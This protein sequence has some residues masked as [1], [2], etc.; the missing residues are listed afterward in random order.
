MKRLLLACAFLLPIGAVATHAALAAG[1]SAQVA[2]VSAGTPIAGQAVVVV[3]SEGK[4][5]G[6]TDQN[7]LFSV[8]ISGKYYRLKVNNKPVTGIFQVSQGTVQVDINNL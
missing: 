2:V 8:P 3:A 5:E 7:G 1:G 4:Y 6:V